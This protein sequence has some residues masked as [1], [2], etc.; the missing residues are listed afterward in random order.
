MIVDGQG[1]AA[2]QFTETWPEASRAI[3]GDAQAFARFL[4]APM[5][6]LAMPPYLTESAR[7]PEGE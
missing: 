3:R 6:A 5:Q 2:G 4:A 1:S 7:G